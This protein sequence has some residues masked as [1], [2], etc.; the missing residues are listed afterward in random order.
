MQIFSD[1]TYP[2]GLRRSPGKYFQILFGVLLLGL[3]I[4]PSVFAQSPVPESELFEIQISREPTFVADGQVNLSESYGGPVIVAGGQVDFS[5]TAQQDLVV[6]GGTI[7]VS[8]TVEQ[9]L[10]ATGGSIIISGEVRGNVVAA[11]GEIQLL[12]TAQIDGS[13]IAAAEKIHVNNYLQQSGWLAGDNIFIIQGSNRNLNVASE[14]LFLAP[15]ASI[16]GNLTARVSEEGYDDQASVAGQRDIQ[17]GEVD[18]QDGPMSE[19]SQFFYEFA[20]RAIFLGTLLLLIPSTV[21][22]GAAQL[23]NALLKSATNGMLWLAGI[24]LLIL[25]LFVTIIGIPL[26]GFLGL[27]YLAVVLLSWV[28]PTFAL[29]ER[30]L[31]GKSEWFQAGAALLV[32]TLVGMLPLVG[33]LLNIVLVVLGT[34]AL[35]SLARQ[36]RSQITAKK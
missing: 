19:V 35:W 16:A 30:L 20:W 29:G 32:V 24:P 21:K 10:Y 8:G 5:G 25:V 33:T 31:P 6:A 18:V 11:G 14:S 15:S 1:S 2:H 36:S 27:L 3:S 26:A 12:S 17:Y 28:F 22:K 7:R 13:V 34:G 9:D 4:V 23:K